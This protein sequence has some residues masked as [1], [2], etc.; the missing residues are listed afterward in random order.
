VIPEFCGYSNDDGTDYIAEVILPG[1]EKD[2]IKLK[3]NADNIFVVGESDSLK[4]AGAYGLCCPVD[5]DKAKAKYNN[6]LL[7]IEV[8]YKDISLNTIDVKID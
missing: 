3:I 2:T 1:V 4:Y 7:K 8:P 6:G 5:A